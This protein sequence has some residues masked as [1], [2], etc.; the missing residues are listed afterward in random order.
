M[1]PSKEK[2][3]ARFS[4]NNKLQKRR[5]KNPHARASRRRTRL[6]FT[7]RRG[8]KGARACF[9]HWGR[10][11]ACPEPSIEW[12][13]PGPPA[14]I[15]RGAQAPP[16]PPAPAPQPATRRRH[17]RRNAP[18]APHSEYRPHACKNKYTQDAQLT[19]DSCRGAP[20]GP[21]LAFPGGVWQ[22]S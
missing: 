10:P 1:N 20:Y 9:P 12:R 21:P 7:F 11:R 6:T 13:D 4:S 2:P 5:T 16:R 15:A 17:A 8:A 18:H 19:F 3:Y 14:S 22:R